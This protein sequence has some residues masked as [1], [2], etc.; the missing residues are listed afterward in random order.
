MDFFYSAGA[1][2]II[3]ILSI[4]NLV[5]GALIFFSCRCIPGMKWGARLMKS[6]WFK[7][8]YRYHCYIWWVFWVSVV[9]H[10]II[11]ILRV[12]SPF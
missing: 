6:G 12:G 3:F 4:I 7:Q 1:A 10:A 8:F 9:V 5:T 2:K 11:A